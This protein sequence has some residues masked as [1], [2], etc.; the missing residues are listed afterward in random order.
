MKRCAIAT[1]FPLILVLACTPEPPAYQSPVR[2][3]SAAPSSQ[4]KSSTALPPSPLQASFVDNFDRPNTTLGLGDGWD[5][6]GRFPGAYPIPL[7]AATD[8]FIS[9]GNYTYAGESSVYAAREF[10]GNITRMGAEGLWRRTRRGAETTLAMAISPN[11]QLITDM[12]HFAANRSVWNLTLRRGNGAFV[13]VASGPFSP[14]LELDREYKF[15]MEVSDNTITVR[16]PGSEVTKSA[17]TLGLLGTHGFWQEYPPKTPAGVVF[18]F[19][20]VWAA[21]EGQPLFPVA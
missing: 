4:L 16:V 2:T 7:P 9:D 1:A 12:I 5:M 13:P 14:I 8:G 6:R 21:E 10:R 19:N 20:T 11:D 3:S 17:S 15:E 18:D